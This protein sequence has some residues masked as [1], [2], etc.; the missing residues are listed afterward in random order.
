MPR[1]QTLTI[2]DWHPTM[3]PN[4]RNSSRGAHWA[5]ARKKHQIDRDMAWASARQAG[6]EFV[7]GKVRL[8]IVFVYPHTVHVDP[9][10]LTARCKGLID[11][12]KTHQ[13]SR[14]KG[15]T[16]RAVALPV[17]RGFI[18]DDTTQYLDLHVSARTEKGVK[19]IEITL[20][21]IEETVPLLTAG[22]SEAAIEG[23]GEGGE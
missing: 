19:A 10:N 11:G 6:W 9:D 15:S 23:I 18:T 16:I 13:A 20:E 17:R 14:P 7:P 22:R 8:N 21:S 1:S 12:L 2:T 3:N 5:V 4:G